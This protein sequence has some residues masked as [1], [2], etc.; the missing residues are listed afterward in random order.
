MS[1]TRSFLKSMSLTEEQINAIMEEHTAVTDALKQQRDDYKA[2][3]DKLSTVQKELD[4]LKG[5]EDYKAKYENEHKAFEDYKV[6]IAKDAET[7]KV[8]GAYRNLLKAEKVG[9]KYLDTVMN[10]TKFDDMKL[11]KDG[12]LES[13]DELKKAIKEKWSD[14]VVK[15]E[16][17][18][19]KVETPPQ[20][21]N[22]GKPMSHAAE[23]AAQYHAQKYGVVNTQKE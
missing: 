11:D 4:D 10:V 20:G 12:N 17:R 8:K 23:R 14:F 22:G 1:L 19:P 9:A 5:G 21:D 15:T 7:E 6:K 16:E 3:A 13:A 18:V 2:D